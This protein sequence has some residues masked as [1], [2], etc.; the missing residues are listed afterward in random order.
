MSAAR[1]FS[2]KLVP[3][4]PERAVMERP[5]ARIPYNLMVRPLRE[6]PMRKIKAEREAS[7]ERRARIS[8]TA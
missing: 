2:R 6:R 8:D 5:K 3:R 7:E 1:N 4:D